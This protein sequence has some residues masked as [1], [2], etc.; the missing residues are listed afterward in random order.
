MELRRD[1]EITHLCHSSAR[2][3]HVAARRVTPAK[4]S[5]LIQ[6][7]F[8]NYN[9]LG[10]LIHSTNAAGSIPETERSSR[11]RQANCNGKWLFF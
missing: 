11:C 8:F 10:G 9:Q 7:F 1:G 4:V 5:I 3:Q 6:G 2:W